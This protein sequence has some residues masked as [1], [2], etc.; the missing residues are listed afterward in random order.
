[1]GEE[2]GSAD[3]RTILRAALGGG[4]I[5]S[6]GLAGRA[7]AAASGGLGL[8]DLPGRLAMITGAG[9]NV[10]VA[11][12]A[13]GAVVVDSGQA[14]RAS[15]LLAVIGQRTGGKKPATLINTCWRLDQTGGN[16][17]FGA[18][19][20]RIVAQVNTALWMGTE[21][22]SRWENRIYPPRAPV[23]RP[24]VSFYDKGAMPLGDEQ[25]EYGYLLQAHT[26]G[27]AYV[28]FRKAN[29]LV[30]GAAVAGRG[31]PVIDWETGGW[32]G[33]HVRGLETMIKLA[34]DKTVI[35]P[36][37]GA[38]LTRADLE[39]QRVMY[40]AIMGKMQAIMESGQGTP[41][42]LKSRPAADYEA[43]RGDATVFLTQAFKSFW[44]HIRQF[45]AI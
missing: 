28:F 26:D 30:A 16:D 9:T 6:F 13:D 3:R 8:R 19:G 24:T 5:A 18:G 39:K 21:I 7:L 20:T 31:W 43:E 34:D 27:D 10:V 22:D 40:V 15:E 41:E 11:P 36:A 45:K 1:M 35:V 12:G 37:D 32:I 4:A 23:A 14:A 33:G 42:V 38:V 44:G 25:I 17:L 2:T 29:V